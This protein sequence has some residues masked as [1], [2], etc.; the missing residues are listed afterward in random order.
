MMKYQGNDVAFRGPQAAK[1][2]NREPWRIEARRERKKAI[3]R[4]KVG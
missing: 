4:S 1:V 2:E 3:S